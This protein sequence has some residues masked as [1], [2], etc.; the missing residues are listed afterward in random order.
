MDKKTIIILIETIAILFVIFFMWRYFDSKLNVYDQNLIAARGEIITLKLKNN[1]LL[2]IRD[3][4]IIKEKD[5]EEQLGISKKEMKEL[6]KKLDASITYI[7]KL[8]S[9]INSGE[10]VTNR[11]SIIYVSKNLTKV[12][13]SY[14]DK[15]MKINGVNNLE[16][17]SDSLTNIQTILN[18]IN[19]TTNLKVGLTDKKQLFVKSDNPYLT[20]TQIDGTYLDKDV[21]QVKRIK[22]SWG[23]QLGFGANY[24]LINKKMDVGPYAGF[25]IGLSF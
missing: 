9:Q 21:A 16:F 22:F 18:N 12:N 1:E 5:L 14:S 15:W 19:I 20:F 23:F 10:I 24:G 7:S 2:Q 6:E 11:D 4:Y 8:E 17:K 13:F 25:G 3:S